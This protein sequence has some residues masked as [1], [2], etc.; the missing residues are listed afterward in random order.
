MQHFLTRLQNNTYRPHIT[1]YLLINYYSS[2][3][4]VRFSSTACVSHT[5]EWPISTVRRSRLLYL[6][7]S[8]LHLISLQEDYR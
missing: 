6:L 3:I 7:K 8:S 5:T 1:Y 4:V 2:Q